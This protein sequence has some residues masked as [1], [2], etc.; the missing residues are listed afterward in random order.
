MNTMHEP[1]FS[2]APKDIIGTSNIIYRRLIDK[3]IALY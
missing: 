2:F 1:K 3:I